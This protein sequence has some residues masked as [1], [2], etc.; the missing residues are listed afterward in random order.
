MQ[1]RPSISIKLERPLQNFPPD[2]RCT[3]L[4][5]DLRIIGKIAIKAQL[6]EQILS[7]TPQQLPANLTNHLQILE[8]ILIKE[9][10]HNINAQTA[11]SVPTLSL[12]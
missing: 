4:T 12:I 3:W 10:K 8:A 2:L 11:G 6:T 5:V 9:L 7:T 1:L